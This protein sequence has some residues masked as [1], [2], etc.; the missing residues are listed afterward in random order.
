LDLVAPVTGITSTVPSNSCELCDSTGFNT[1]SGTSMATPHVSGTVA[2]LLEADPTLTPAE[3]KTIL[4]DSSFD[5]GN[6]GFDSIFGSGRV[7][8]FA[9]Y[10][11]L[12][13]ELPV[14]DPP[15]PEPPVTEPPSAPITLQSKPQI[16][17]NWEIE[18]TTIGQADLVITPIDGTN[19]IADETSAI[20]L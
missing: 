8:A 17:G 19:W 4:K 13:V 3:I 7:D 9:A 20:T 15:F 18:F 16:D 10:E 5:L 11:S 6:S 14:A 1:L 2:L 12:S